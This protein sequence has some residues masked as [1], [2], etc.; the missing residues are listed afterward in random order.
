MQKI[1]NKLSTMPDTQTK[2]GSPCYLV[3]ELKDKDL[4]PYGNE[5][6][7]YQDFKTAKLAYTKAIISSIGRGKTLLLL[8]CTQH[9]FLK[10]ELKEI[11]LG[12]NLPIGYRLPSEVLDMYDY[13]LD[14]LIDG[15]N[16]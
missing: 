9:Y 8:E 10:F 5:L 6:N 2:S 7:I 3:L 15:L 16:R 14:A 12:Y 4:R 1:E 11:C 13:S